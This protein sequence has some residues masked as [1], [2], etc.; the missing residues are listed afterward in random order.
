MGHAIVGQYLLE[1]FYDSTIFDVPKYYEPQS[2]NAVHNYTLNMTAEE[3]SEYAFSHWMVNTV[4]V[5]S[6]AM[7]GLFE[8]SNCTMCGSLI[9]QLNDNVRDLAAS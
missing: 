5:V 4:R 6:G 3:A 7:D 9:I 8:C 1:G 2:P